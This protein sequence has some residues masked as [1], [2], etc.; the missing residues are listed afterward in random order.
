MNNAHDRY[1]FAVQMLKETYP[2]VRSVDV[3]HYLGVSKAAVSI[4]VRQLR[5]QELMEMEPDG[6]LVFTDKGKA[7]S[8][9]LR[10]RVLFFQQ[11]LTG[12]GVEPSLAMR[13]AISF[14]WE[15]SDD[16]FEAFRKL[17]A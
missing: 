2:C 14:S 12:A 15:M 10:T 13:D 9:R 4:V 6:N 1:L 5:E 11:L 16:S 8:D 17:M 3:A 7:Y